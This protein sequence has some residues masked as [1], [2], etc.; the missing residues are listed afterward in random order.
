M[1]K[2]SPTDLPGRTIEPSSGYSSC[3]YWGAKP[4]EP[5][6]GQRASNLITCLI[7]MSNLKNI[8]ARGWYLM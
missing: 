1:K 5:V 8:R 3:F 4:I 7:P 2:K 6:S